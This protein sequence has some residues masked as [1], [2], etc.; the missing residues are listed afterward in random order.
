[1]YIYGR[2]QNENQY[3]ELEMLEYLA[4]NIFEVQNKCYLCFEW[5]LKIICFFCLRF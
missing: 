1:M 3:N 5:F 4:M 2:A